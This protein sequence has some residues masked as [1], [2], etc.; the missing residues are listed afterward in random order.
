MLLAESITQD[1]F[2][3]LNLMSYIAFWLR[4]FLANLAER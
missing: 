3:A 2:T 4:G 1:L